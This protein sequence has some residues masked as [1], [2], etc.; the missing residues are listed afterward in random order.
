MN[1]NPKNPIIG[2]RSF[3]DDP[4]IAA[5]Y[6]KAMIEGLH[7]GSAPTGCLPVEIPAMDTSG[8]FTEE[9]LYPRGFGLRIEE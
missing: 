5:D 2:V 3:S 4:A 1:T 8:R 7:D 6:G 9:V